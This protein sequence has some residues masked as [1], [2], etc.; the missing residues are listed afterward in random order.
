MEAAH[1]APTPRRPIAR[2]AR[3]LVEP[4]TW[5]ALVYL[6]TSFP[7]GTAWFVALVVAIA[8]GVSTAII[9]VGLPI[10]AATVLVWRWGARAERRWVEI[11]LGVAIADP[12]RP[13]P[14]GTRRR[15]WAVLLRD[16]A[17]WK[18]LLYLF[19]RFP[20]G[21]AYFVITVTLWAWALWLVFMPAYYWLLPDGQA[22][23]FTD[24]NDSLLVID[25]PLEAAIC[26]LVGLAFVVLAA[27]ATRGLG[28]LQGLIARGLLGAGR[29]Q[30]EARVTQLDVSPRRG[31]RHCRRRSAAA[32][33]ATCTTAPSSGWS[34]SRWTSAWPARSSTATPT[35]AARAWSPRRTRRPSARSPS[36][37]TSSRGI[38]P[39]VLT[40]RGLDAALSARRRALARPGRGRRRRAR[41][42][43]TRADRGGRL[44]RRRRGPRPT[45][46]ST[47]PPPRAHVRVRRQR[48]PAAWSRSRTTAPAARDR[49][50]AP[51]CA[52]SPTASTAVD[53]RL[54]V[55]SPPGGPTTSCARSCRARRDRRGLACCCARA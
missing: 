52:A 29:G 21:V 44:L 48:R 7:I 37:A 40:D 11:A 14:A 42:R 43:P 53:G 47:P 49:R 34:R 55:A 35:A 45:S 32:S 26:T 12:H 31:G 4:S 41:A 50:A 38:H 5:L 46:P 9:W 39:A 1:A 8:V 54:P 20:L 2:L 18:D 24:G 28:S 10:L 27:W 36:C 25:H 51:A 23:L 13:L 19:L 3:V 16:P 33:S 6:I 17:T 22:E 30:L 15:R